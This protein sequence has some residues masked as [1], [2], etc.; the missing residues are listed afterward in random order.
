L[1]A[2]QLPG[3][4]RLPGQ[5]LSFNAS[6]VD[7]LSGSTTNVSPDLW[8]LDHMRPLQ[9]PIRRRWEEYLFRRIQEETAKNIHRKDEMQNIVCASHLAK[10]V[11]KMVNI[12][13]MY[14]PKKTSVFVL[15]RFRHAG[16]VCFQP[17]RPSSLAHSK[18]TKTPQ[19]GQ[20]PALAGRYLLLTVWNLSVPHMAHSGEKRPRGFDC[21]G[22]AFACSLRRIAL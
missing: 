21:C 1:L 6:T 3:L 16:H 18:Q 12:P 4:F 11:L 15:R 19:D 7:T 17:H 10:M 9:S 14:A 8:D 13:P 20:K 2:G 5:Y 22:E